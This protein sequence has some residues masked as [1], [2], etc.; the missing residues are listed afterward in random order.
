MRHDVVAAARQAIERSEDAPEVHDAI[1]LLDS[2]FHPDFS[3]ESDLRR[4]SL[5]PESESRLRFRA[6]GSWARLLWSKSTSVN[7]DEA[8]FLIRALAHPDRWVRAQASFT[9]ERIEPNRMHGSIR[10]KLVGAVTSMF[11]REKTL[12]AK[13]YGARALDRHLGGNR[14]Q[15]VKLAFER[16][17]LPHEGSR[18]AFTVRTGLSAAEV[19]YWL[20]RAD[21]VQHAFFDVLGKAASRPVRDD[22]NS[23]WRIFIFADRA[24]YQAYLEAFIGFGATA[25]GLYL[26]SA[27]TLYTY[28]RTADQSRYTLEELLQHELTHALSA[29]FIFPGTW[30]DIGYHA[31]PKGWLDE[32]LAEVMAGLP[33]GQRT[34][35]TLRS[36]PLAIVCEQGP[37]DLAALLTR[38][39]GYDRPGEFAYARAWSFVYYLVDEAPD[40]L[41]R[42]LESFRRDEFSAEGLAKL[43]RAPSLRAVEDG[44]HAAIKRWCVTDSTE[45]ASVVVEE[46]QSPLGR[47]HSV[48]L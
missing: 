22:N 31:K 46:R 34:A 11:D 28:Q 16:R 3:I 35:P 27:A 15:V 45:S 29:R 18:G 4:I 25:G 9:V 30:D 42:V 21:E 20:K 2:F 17:A 23:H 24:Q 7:A 33:K 14:A 32:G 36:T 40:T 47:H 5:A 10:K 37:G 1:W 8:L 12:V 19:P 44:W 6:L 48:P 39:A 26:E 41:H 13:A 43:A 38:R